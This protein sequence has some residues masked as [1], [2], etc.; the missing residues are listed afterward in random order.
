MRQG[1]EKSNVYA[2]CILHGENAEAMLNFFP[3]PLFGG[4][5]YVENGMKPL[6]DEPGK[7]AMKPAYDTYTFLQYPGRWNRACGCFGVHA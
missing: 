6:I 5:M 7:E 3:L 2:D 4:E 1:M